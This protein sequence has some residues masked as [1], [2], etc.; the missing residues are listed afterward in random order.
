MQRHLSYGL[1]PPGVIIGFNR[2]WKDGY[3]HCLWPADSAFVCSHF[4]SQ[5]LFK[6]ADTMTFNFGVISEAGCILNEIEI[7]LRNHQDPAKR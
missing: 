4:E 3:T 2:M 7:A 6:V 1:L 5:L